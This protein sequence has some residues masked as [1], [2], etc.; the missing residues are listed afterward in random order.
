MCLADIT[1]DNPNVWFE[2]GFAI[3]CKKEVVLVCSEART[4]KFPFDVQHR[5]IIMYNTASPSE[6]DKLRAKITQ[7]LHAYLEKSEA[8][9]TVSEV[10][11][12]TTP[13][14]GFADHEVVALAVLAQNLAHEDDSVSMYQIRRDMES[15]GFTRVAAT[16][17]IKLLLNK[18]LIDSQGCTD[19]NGEPY[20]AYRLTERGWSWL[21]A[22]QEKFALTAPSPSTGR[23]PTGKK[24][25]GDFDDDI[26]F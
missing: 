25:A 3:A 17:A 20:V 4:T 9:A 5:T 18:Q 13:T 7:K 1:L 8:L 23:K 16:L 14:A 2:L 10:S 21:I 6:F 19:Q 22:N 15:S 26:P 11:Q 24:N 12:L